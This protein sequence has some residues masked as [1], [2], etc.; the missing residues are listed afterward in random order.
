MPGEH[1]GD[2][3]LDR[4]EGVAR[5]RA[6]Q[7]VEHTRDLIE[8]AARALEG[9]DRVGEGRR[10]GIPGDGYDLGGVLRERLVEGRAE[11]I[12]RD[13]IERR[14]PERRRPFAEERVGR[15]F[16]C[17]AGLDLVCAHGVSR[18]ARQLIAQRAVRT[19]IGPFQRWLLAALRRRYALPSPL[20]GG[21]TRAAARAR[22]GGQRYS[23]MRWRR[24]PPP[25]PP[26][27]SRSAP[28]PK[29]R[30]GAS[31]G[32]PVGPPPPP[33]VPGLAL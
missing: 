16:A 18:F 32:P 21:P 1:R 9:V 26:L 12:G 3:A 17:G 11:V 25:P 27:R 8:A 19:R 24:H 29:G 2:L 20:W 15:G 30:A 14:Q 33:P 31:A 10:I 22:R 6:G 23:R 5:V 13:L 4:L 7:V 28:P